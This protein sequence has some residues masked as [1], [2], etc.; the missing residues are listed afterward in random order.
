MR[1]LF[2]VPPLAGHVNPTV[3]VAA[4]LTARGHQ[5][6]WT[7][8]AE[9]LPSLL[10]ARATLLPA[11]DRTGPGGY[12]T[13]HGRWRDLRGVAALRF[14]W[15]EALI[16]LAHA[17]LPGVAAAVDAYAPDVLVADQ[18]ALAGAV[19][20]RRRGLPWV[21]SATTTAE[22]TRPFAGFPKVGEW[23]T[24]RIAGFLTEA[25]APADW[26]PRFSD[27]LVVVFSTPNS[28]A[29]TRPVPITTP[30]SDPR[31]A[32]ARQTPR[33]SPGGGWIPYD[34]GCWS[35]SAPSTARRAAVSTPPSCGPR[36]AWPTRSS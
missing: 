19:I 35:R 17:M 31:W 26:D 24:D 13:L 3:A 25:G 22:F 18:Q 21:T 20:A 4:E 7:G 2:V 11:G 27:R 6:A 30:S 1:V 32:P 29:R 34:A 10:P 36:S 15:E 5:V 33:P 23:V 8:P 14:L 12:G 28:S 16:P 9:V